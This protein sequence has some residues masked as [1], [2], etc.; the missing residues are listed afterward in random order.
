M[1]KLV[2]DIVSV[3]TVIRGIDCGI[4]TV[5]KSWKNKIKSGQQATDF[6]SK[7]MSV[8]IRAKQMFKRMTCF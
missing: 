8:R 5:A 7:S 4:A 6:G 2:L 3:T 1:R